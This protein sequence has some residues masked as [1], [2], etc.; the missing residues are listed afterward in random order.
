MDM[1]KDRKLLREAIAFGVRTAA[2]LALYVRIQR[3]RNALG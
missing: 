1:R 2:E 3:G